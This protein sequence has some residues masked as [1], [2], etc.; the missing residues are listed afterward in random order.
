M[1]WTDDPLTAGNIFINKVHF[2]ELHYRLW[3]LYTDASLTADTY[4]NFSVSKFPEFKADEVNVS[5]DEPQVRNDWIYEIRNAINNNDLLD[6]YGY[7]NLA[8]LLTEAF[9]QSNWTDVNLIADETF[10]RNDHIIELRQA[11]DKLEAVVETVDFQERWI[12]PNPIYK[13]TYP[14]QYVWTTTE[15]SLLRYGGLW[16]SIIATHTTY[17]NVSADD[18]IDHTIHDPNY[19]AGG[20][21]IDYIGDDKWGMSNDDVEFEVNA[22]AGNVIGT[23]TIGH[24]TIT[25]Y[26]YIDGISSYGISYSIAWNHPTWSQ[27]DSATH[28]WINVGGVSKMVRNLRDDFTS[29]FPSLVWDGAHKRIKMYVYYAAGSYQRITLPYQDWG[30]TTSVHLGKIYLRSK[31]V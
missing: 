15:D 31:P 20:Y 18:G 11:L 10:I 25:L 29:K 7:D 14:N 19:W 5:W 16:Y 1:A 17:F 23:T 21:Y 28:K 13:G 12:D 6:A 22:T 4:A 2:T 8:E 24:V 27:I 9:G 30:G 26:L 3:E